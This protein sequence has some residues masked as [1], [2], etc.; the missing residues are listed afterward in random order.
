MELGSEQHKRLLRMSIM[1][2]AWKTA[3]IGLFFGFLLI[4]P[5][6]IRDNP[7]VNGLALAGYGLMLSFIGYA[8]Y[9]AWRKYQKIFKTF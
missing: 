2:V 8:L 9:I 1:K 4:I 6:L 5:S 7:L 3:S